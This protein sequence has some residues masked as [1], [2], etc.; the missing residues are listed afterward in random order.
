MDKILPAQC[1]FH[2]GWLVPC[3]VCLLWRLRRPRGRH[4]AGHCGE[5]YLPDRDGCP[6]RVFTTA[7]VGKIVS[8]LRWF[9]PPIIDVLQLRP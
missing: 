9:V 4:A 2:A 6:V 8:P 1:L 3:I 5:H 7:R